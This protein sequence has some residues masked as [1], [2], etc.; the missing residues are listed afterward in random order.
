MFSPPLPSAAALPL[1]KCLE[2]VW[3]Q[4]NSF[5]HQIRGALVNVS[6]HWSHF[7]TRLGGGSESCASSDANASNDSLNP[8]QK[9]RRPA[10]E[11]GAVGR[12]FAVRVCGVCHPRSS[13]A[14]SKTEA[15]R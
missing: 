10:A 14:R 7:W 12:L 4:I 6:V 8:H 11:C 15:K 1:N 5:R 2:R 3:T 9:T 13:T